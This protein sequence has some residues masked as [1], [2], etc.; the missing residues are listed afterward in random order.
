MSPDTATSSAWTREHG[1]ALNQGRHALLH[2]NVLDQCLYKGKYLTPAEYVVRHAMDAGYA[3]VAILNLAD[4]LTFPTEEMRQEFE[5]ITSLRH[6][7]EAGD[8]QAL[9][10]L[11]GADD[12]AAGG[13]GAGQ[14]TRPT[15]RAARRGSQATATRFMPILDGMC[16]LRRA[17]A[18]S[19]VPV[20]VVICGPE[21]LF[22]G[23]DHHGE[24]ERRLLA[25]MQ[26]MQQEAAFI[27][28]GPL[29]GRR[30]AITLVTGQLGLLPTCLYQD[31]PFVALVQVPRPS[32]GERRAYFMRFS[33]NSHGGGELMPAEMEQ[34]SDQFVASTEGFMHWELEAMRRTSIAEK[35]DIRNVRDLVMFFRYGERED[36]W[37][38]ISAA[39]IQEAR[40]VL[41]QRVVG[42]PHA[43]EAVA[44]MLLRA[45][46]GL[47]VTPP[48]GSEGQPKGNLVFVGPTGV[49]KSELAKGASASVFGN[50]EAYFRLDMSEYA[51]AHSAERMTG[52]PPGYVGHENGGHLT[53]RVRERPFSLLLFDE[54]EKAHPRILDKFLQVLEDGRLTD[55]LGQTA[56]FGQTV[57]IFTSNIGTA[58]LDPH[59]AQ[60]MTYEEVGDHFL[61]AVHTF[62]A[63]P[64]RADGTGGIGRPELLNRLGDGIVVFDVLREEHVRGIAAKFLGSLAQNLRRRHDVDM[65]YDESVTDWVRTWMAE[66]DNMLFGGRRIKTLIETRIVTPLSRWVFVTEP[67]PGQEVA[68][69]VNGGPLL[70]NGQPVPAS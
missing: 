53:N 59:E 60:E 27:K 45:N 66:G 12:A 67:R 2:G 55:G 28:H 46:T 8:Q 48:S 44:S 33:R 40:T 42:Q 5:R 30:N 18:Q 47:S 69:S 34:I 62:F 64:P 41:S 22:S 56:Y 17:V 25:V 70:V 35:I 3:I 13:A 32:Q 21:R 14:E 10:G 26:S 58:T 24:D 6:Q 38:K 51:E 4:G 61:T 15:T 31:N 16:R 11:A 54:I 68:L 39:R 7:P 65:T 9:P 19:E 63:E 29:S 37:E 23:P 49:G 20:A 50:E 36:P 57:L 1:R 43:V 52:S